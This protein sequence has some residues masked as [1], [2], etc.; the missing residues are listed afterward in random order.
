MAENTVVQQPNDV[1]PTIPRPFRSGD[2]SKMKK[3]PPISYAETIVHLLK[4]N[5]GIGYFAI[6]EAIKNCGL[7]LGPLFIVLIALICVHVQHILISCAEE[8]QELYQMK[9]KPDYAQTVEMCFVSNLRWRKSAG[10]AKGI[11]NGFICVT[12][13]GFCSVYLLFFGTS[14]KEVLSY[15]G[16]DYSIFVLVAILVIPILITSLITDLKYIGMNTH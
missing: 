15:H 10:L 1:R 13:L 8:M 3:Q 4:G 2:L 16:Y 14:L 7:I 5:I 11:C 6:S 12:Q 9:D